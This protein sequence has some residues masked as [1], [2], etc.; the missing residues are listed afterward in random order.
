MSGYLHP[1]ERRRRAAHDAMLTALQ[2]LHDARA[3]ALLA[4]GTP[5]RCDAVNEA[6]RIADAALR[7]M[8]RATLA[9]K[10]VEFGGGAA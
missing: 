1:A 3:V 8:H 10:W 7:G 6:Y 2:C 4:A 5:Q 9:E